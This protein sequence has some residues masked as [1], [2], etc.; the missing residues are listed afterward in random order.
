MNKLIIGRHDGCLYFD[1]KEK[2]EKHKINIIGEL[3]DIK[4]DYSSR[5]KEFESLMLS[6]PSNLLRTIP[7]TRA[8]SPYVIQ[9][10]EE[11]IAYLKKR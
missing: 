7:E 11:G 6:I 2:R 9:V 4:S 1:E 5:E 8:D 10:T 3:F